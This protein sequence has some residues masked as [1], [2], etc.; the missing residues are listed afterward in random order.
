M[1]E[2]KYHISPE[3]GNPN[4]C[5]AKTAD[6]CKFSENGTVEV[7]H[8]ESKAEARAGYEAKMEAEAKAEREAKAA[9]RKEEA[10][11]NWPIPN[12]DK[13][14]EYEAKGYNVDASY[15][16]LY[17]SDVKD[18]V[19]TTITVMNG[20]VSATYQN[21]FESIGTPLAFRSDSFAEP[22]L[23]FTDYGTNLSEDSAK[24]H[25]AD[26]EELMNDSAKFAEEINKTVDD[27]EKLYGRPKKYTGQQEHY[28]KV[29]KFD[30]SLEDRTKILESEEDGF[31]FSS[32]KSYVHRGKEFTL[33]VRRN[34]E[35]DKITAEVNM[36]SMG[37]RSDV[38]AYKERIYEL[39]NVLATA[40]ELKKKV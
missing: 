27:A 12:S 38:E 13:I 31:D 2:V 24:K 16:E 19:R 7:E 11:K 25:L 21:N 22:A 8:Y 37:S 23:E 26:M 5:R 28:A 30:N 6:S 34:R 39:R 20:R 3:T 9:K 29:G 1:A 17:K 10:E 35:D 40:E 18:N 32:K 33:Y 14:S 4:I 36:T 15:K